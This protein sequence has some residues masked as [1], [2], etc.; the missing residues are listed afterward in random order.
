M[1]DWLDAFIGVGIGIVLGV[2]G[3][4]LWLLRRRGP[5]E[6]EMANLRAR[7]ELLDEQAARHVEELQLRRDEF[8]ETNTRREEAQRQ[9]VAMAEQ[10]K[11]REVQFEE[12]KKLLEDAKIRLNE[13]FRATGAEALAANNKQF[14]E[15]AKK[16]LET[17]MT[18]AKGDLEKKQLAIEHLVKP[19]K[20]LLEKQNS[21]VT[22]IEKK[23]DVAY[24][25]LEEQFKH[26]AES[27]EKLGLETGRLVSA[28]R[29]PE[30]RG[31][32]GEMQ[33]RNVVELAGMTEHC[34][35]TEQPQTDDPNTRDR[36]DMTIRMPDGGV[37][38]VD[39]K[40]AMDAYLDAIDPDADKTERLGAHA[41]QVQD[42]VAR[43][44][45][46]RY[47]DQFEHTPTVVV[48]FM[49]LESA[50][51][52]ALE[53][54]PDLQVEAMRQHVFI[55]T[56][57]HLVML[58]QSAAYGWQ[59]EAL[60]KNAKD[61]ADVGRDLYK[62]VGTFV[63]HFEKI[64]VNLRRA[65]ES[66]NDAVGSLERRV[67]SSTRKLKELNATTDIDIET[68]DQV[69]IEVR[70]INAPELKSLPEEIA[71][72]KEGAESQRGAGAES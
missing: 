27:H 39:S 60:A 5:R 48:M 59:Q 24:K 8:E 26:I 42:H 34:D 30:Q 43:L 38:V 22:E 35:F 7:T 12:Q 70:R 23:R 17:H 50:L 19:I 29:R 52:A 1:I 46:K 10:N 47:W 67:L 33:L 55:A 36:P 40:V 62:R 64:G 53:I 4:G 72:P 65:S 49:P 61:I 41:K 32:W 2:I 63:E 6:L 69:E 21:A 20:E 56:P 37:I 15:L 28:L 13:S 66:Y 14:L 25:G 54:M 3:S 16:V 71:S 51:S 31:R 45:K 44:A 58:L 68:P 11:A 9:V 18:A 57:L